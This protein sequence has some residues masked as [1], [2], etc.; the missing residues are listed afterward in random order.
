MKNVKKLIAVILTMLMIFTAVSILSNC[1]ASEPET[2]EETHT[3][4]F[5][6]NVGNIDLG[7]D[8]FAITEMYGQIINWLRVL[9][10]NII[11]YIERMVHI[12]NF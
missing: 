1:V 4:I 2:V 3:L 10:D 11:N 7:I 6:K 9:V 8:G 5:E 12:K